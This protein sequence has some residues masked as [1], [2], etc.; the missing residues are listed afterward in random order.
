M[1]KTIYVSFALSLLLVGCNS[2]T[3]KPTK[4][5]KP[6][7]EKAIEEIAEVPTSL[8]ERE[9][10]KDVV[11]SVEG[12]DST[13]T[14]NLV[15]GSR[16][17]YSLY[18]D[19]E[20]YTFENGENEDKLTPIAKTPT[21]Y[22]E[23]YMTFLYIE[24]QN[25]ESVKEEM[26]QQYKMSL[27]EQTISTPVHALSLHGTTGQKSDSEVVTIYIMEVERGTLLIKENYFLEAQEG[28]G[29]RFEQMLKTLEVR[30]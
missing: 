21:D 8:P 1:R 2:E 15:E 28:H 5:V 20:R 27:E 11:L 29:A 7:G 6:S 10:T 12:E 4:E 13:I 30:N 14:M 26:K 16:A 22:P 3:E 25:P 23:V 19:P 17:L 9:P 18:I 24:N